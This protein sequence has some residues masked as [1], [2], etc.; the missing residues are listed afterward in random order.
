MKIDEEDNEY[1]NL[2][3][4]ELIIKNQHLG[5]F[6]LRDKIHNYVRLA[7]LED[8]KIDIESIDSFWTKYHNRKDYTL[9]S[10]PIALKTLNSEGLI[11]LEKSVKLIKEIQQISEKGYRHLLNDFIQLN[12]ATNIIPF[13][14]NNFDHRELNVD[15]LKLP[16]EYINKISKRTFN[17]ELNELIR[18]HRNTSIPLEEIENILDSNKSEQ[19][20]LVL[21]QIKIPVSY[22]YSETKTI[23]KF[24]NSKLIFRKI[25]EEND[26]DKYKQSITQKLERGILTIEDISFIKKKQLAPDEIARYSDGYYSSLPN[27]NIFKIYEPSEINKKFKAILYNTLINKTKSINYFYALYYHPGNILTM[28]KLYRNDKEF[29]EASKSFEKYINLSMFNLKLGE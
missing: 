21:N 18:Y 13:L 7:V 2:T 12:N 20:K 3:L 19:L 22:K 23:L 24:Q 28:I 27:I 10:I 1:H 8:R 14:E 26:R 5:S 11:T 6:D 25:T 4:Q 15:W 17:I 9:Y 16:K 29:I